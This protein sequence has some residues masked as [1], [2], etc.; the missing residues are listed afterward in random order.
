MNLQPR[1]RWLGLDLFR[2]VAAYAV[3]QVHSGDETWGIPVEPSATTFRLLLYFAVPFFLATSL[4]F[5]VRKAADSNTWSFWKARIDRILIPYAIWSAIYLIFRSVFFSLTHD[6]DRLQSLFQDP[7]SIIFFGGASYH[8]YFLPLLLTGTTLALVSRLLEKHKVNTRTLVVFAI[9]SILL[10]TI[11]VASHN[12]FQLGSY[13][14]FANLIESV[15]PEINQNNLVRFIL[16]EISWII[17]CL[18]Y[19]LISMLLV[20]WLNKLDVKRFS[21]SISLV[22]LSGFFL[23]IDVF[24]SALPDSIFDILIAYCLFLIAISISNFLKESRIAKSLGGCSFGIYLIHPILMNVVKP[25][26]HHIFPNFSARISI[27]ST[28]ALCLPTFFLS[29]LVVSQL[30]RNHR[31]SKY[32]FGA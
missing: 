29:W 25:T 28:L 23:I 8:L 12:D 11:V 32:L 5:S 10:H 15:S 20:R 22:A 18:P 17:R 1:I 19:T 7:V 2:G 26:L 9:L 30:S 16:V 21:N 31:L 6:F 24:R 3:V 27:L 13:V 14:A 4:F